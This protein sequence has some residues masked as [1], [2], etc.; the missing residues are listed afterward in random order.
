[1][2][3]MLSMSR[4]ILIF[5]VAFV[6]FIV[7]PAFLSQRFFLYPLITVGDALDLLTSLVLIPLYWL[8]FRLGKPPSTSENI[9]FLVLVGFW[10]SGQGMHLGANSIKHL[11]GELKGT[12]AYLLAE[13][14]D[15]LLGHYLWHIG[16]FGLTALLVWRQVRNPLAAPLASL[17]T[18][19]VCAVIY[20]IITFI[21]VTEGGTVP[22]G[23]PFVAAVTVVGLVQRKH[24]RE[25][26]ITA[27]F[28]W[29]NALALI[30]FV[31]WFVRWG[32][33]PQFSELGLI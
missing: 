13:F 18:E 1:M 9:V 8:L 6:I 25:Q 24:L 32:G 27:Y 21:I 22:L 31:I 29:A 17:R 15:E 7:A 14:Y 5:T 20:G 23:L 4:L 16:L 10:A 28:F 12:D 33:F 19:A 26:P 30:L 11:M 3:V 2:P